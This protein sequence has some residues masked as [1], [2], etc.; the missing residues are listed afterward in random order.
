[1]YIEKTDAFLKFISDD[2]KSTGGSSHTSRKPH[3]IVSAAAERDYNNAKFMYDDFR[4]REARSL[5]KT[6][7]IVARAMKKEAERKENRLQKNLSHIEDT[8]KLLDNV[9]KLLKMNDETNRNSNRR[10]FE[11]WN[12]Q[13]HGRIQMKIA[14]QIDSIDSKT[15]NKKKNDDYQKFIDI[16]NRKPA[17]FRDII[18]ESEYDPLEPNRHSIK[19]RTGVLKDP[20]LMLFRKAADEAAMLGES[21]GVKNLKIAGECKATLPVELWGSGKIEGTPHGRFMKMMNSKSKMTAT[22]KSNL[23]F[24]DYAFPR[25]KAAVDVEM[26]KGKRPY[27]KNIGWDM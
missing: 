12:I 9:D 15:L 17:I 25:G 1:M 8:K 22:M 26:P 13:V 24:D 10:Q 19:A 4:E 27:P 2:T 6:N 21:S 23:T 5:E 14:E 7:E 16:S 18:I 20:T 11:E 3:Q